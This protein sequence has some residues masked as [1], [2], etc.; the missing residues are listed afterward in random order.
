MNSKSYTLD[1]PITLSA[2]LEKMAI[3]GEGIAVAVNNKVVPRSQWSSFML[4]DGA[5]LII[6]KA[7][8]GG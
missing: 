2:F 8:C 4:E 7:V 5:R 6:I 1:A 3:S